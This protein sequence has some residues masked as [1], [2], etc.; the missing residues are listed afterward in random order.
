MDAKE[1]EYLFADEIIALINGET[2]PCDQSVDQNETIED[3]N[4]SNA[5][6]TNLKLIDESEDIFGTQ[7]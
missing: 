3:T 4:K 1:E 2:D 7:T 5:N 6:K